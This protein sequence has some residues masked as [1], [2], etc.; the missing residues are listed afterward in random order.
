VLSQ[1]QRLLLQ[2]LVPLGCQRLLHL[3]VM[4]DLSLLLHAA[5]ARNRRASRRQL[6]QQQLRRCDAAER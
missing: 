2:Q 1:H 4:V 3:Q 5:D 6:Q